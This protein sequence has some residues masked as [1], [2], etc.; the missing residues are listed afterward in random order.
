MKKWGSILLVALLCLA[1][2]GCGKRDQQ[3]IE[4]TVNNFFAAVQEGEWERA[5]EENCTSRYDSGTFRIEDKVAYYYDLIHV[6]LREN[7]GDTFRQEGERFLHHALSKFVP[8]YAIESIEIE[9]G[10]PTK[11]RTARVTVRGKSIDFHQLPLQLEPEAIITQ[12]TNTHLY[13]LAAILRSQ[14]EDAMGRRLYDA[15]APLIYDDLCKQVDEIEPV[16][17]ACV[18]TLKGNDGEWRIDRIQEL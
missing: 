10:S 7:L 1:L 3:A 5:K 8:S 13:E 6:L 2:S 18:L 16:D 4:T 11:E 9:R 12:Y 17:F 14:G 15:V